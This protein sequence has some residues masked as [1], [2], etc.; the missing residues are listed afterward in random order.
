MGIR[1]NKVIG[2]GLTDVVTENGVIT[3]P[4]IN[5][6]SFLLTGRGEDEDVAPYQDWLKQRLTEDPE[7]DFDVRMDLAMLEHSDNPRDVWRLVTYEEEYG[8]PHVLVVRPAGFPEWCRYDDPIDYQEEI[9]RDDHPDAR[10]TQPLGGLYPWNGLHMDARTGKRIEGTLVNAWRRV[11]NGL[12]EGDKDRMKALDLL[13]RR[14]G[15]T[16][17][18]EAERYVVPFVPHEIRNVCAW[19]GLFTSKEVCF[20]LRPLIYTY[21]A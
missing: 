11:A 8:L 16:N 5:A 1:I 3:D 6:D 10:V 15:Y 13:A 21:W 4:R 20:Q 14:L 2:Y 19:G 18:E 7:A 12:P 9:L 17:H